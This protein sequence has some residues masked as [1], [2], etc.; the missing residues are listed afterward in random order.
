M[1][2]LNAV[3]LAQL[4][5]EEAA[6]VE[7]LVEL[8][9]SRELLLLALGELGWVLAKREAGAFE[10]AGE[11][12]LPGAPGPVPNI[13]RTSSSAAVASATT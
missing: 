13:R 11:L 12:S 7:R 4:L 3:D 10:F 9:D 6:A 2:S 1:L 8:L 5:G